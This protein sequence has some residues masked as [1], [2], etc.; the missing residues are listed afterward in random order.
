VVQGRGI[1]EKLI[2]DQPGDLFAQRARV[3]L[4]QPNRI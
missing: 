3:L 4:L 2:V 1:L